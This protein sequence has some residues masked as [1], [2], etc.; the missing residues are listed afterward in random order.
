MANRYAVIMAA[1]LLAVGCAKEK[2]ADQAAVPADDQAA[3]D[4]IHTE[5]VTHFNLHH[6]S[7]VADLHTD[8][9]G[10]F[11]ADGSIDL[12]KPAILKGLEE[13]LAAKPTV[14][15]TPAETKIF[16]DRAITRGSYTLGMTPP[17]GAAISLG[18]SYLTLFER[19]AGTWKIGTVVS[20]YNAVPPAGT[21]RDT[22][23]AVTAP[24]AEAGTMKELVAA[25]TQ[26]YNM[27]HASVVAGLYTDSAYSAFAD[28]PAMQ[29]RAAIESYLTQQMSQG[30]P[31]LTIH[32]ITTTEL[33]GGW[34][35]DGGWYE[36]KANGPQGPVNS[37]GVYVLLAQRQ[38]DNSWKIHWSTNTGG[39]AR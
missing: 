14:T 18:G 39:P 16:G 11:G 19:V 29:G 9:A 32:D 8:S 15:L 2:P 3:I 28:A 4:K 20:N 30:S 6:A 10:F 35:I 38:A 5:Y 22:A 17:G 37:N 7:A 36:V 25:Y 13:T 27:G 34:A 21:P 1:G 23:T 12:G 26:H 33:P 24:P 31:Q